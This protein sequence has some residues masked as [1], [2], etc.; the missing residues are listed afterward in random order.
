MCMSEKPELSPTQMSG[1]GAQFSYKKEANKRYASSV[2]QGNIQKKLSWSGLEKWG[3]A[4]GAKHGMR[5]P[6][7]YIQTAGS[8]ILILKEQFLV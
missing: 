7:L 5:K 8:M 4:S 3:Q 1:T 2:E 6:N